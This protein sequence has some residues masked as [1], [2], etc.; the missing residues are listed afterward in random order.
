MLLLKEVFY[1]LGNIVHKEDHSRWV[2]E[3]CFYAWFK[4]K[5]KEEKKEKSCHIIC[6]VFLSDK[7]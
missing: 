6:L 1:F 2:I 4:K 5:K 7:P 3:E